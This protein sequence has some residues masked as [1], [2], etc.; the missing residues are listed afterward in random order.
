MAD[1][2]H[3]NPLKPWFIGLVIVLVADLYVAYIF[4]SGQCQAPV[5]AQAIVVVVL[6]VVYLVLMYLTFKS[7][8]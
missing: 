1:L 5:I 2:E 8:P 7:Q 6:P 4:F 3:R